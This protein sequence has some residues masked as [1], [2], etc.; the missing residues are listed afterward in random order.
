MIFLTLKMMKTMINKIFNN[1]IFLHS[2]SHKNNNLRNSNILKKKY[3]MR[4]F[5]KLRLLFYKKT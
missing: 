5:L 3:K 4:K 2:N 1:L